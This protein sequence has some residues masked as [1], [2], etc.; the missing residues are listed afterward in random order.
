MLPIR[1]LLPFESNRT[2]RHPAWLDDDD[3]LAACDQK[4]LRRGGP[5]GQ[6]R[7]K[8]ET[9]VRLEHRET[10][11]VAEA[12]EHRTQRE[13]RHVA[14]RRLRLKLALAVRTPPLDYP[15]WA[16]VVA[17]RKVQAT[18]HARTGPQLVAHVLNVCDAVAFDLAAAARLLGVSKSQVVKF[19]R[20]DRTVMTAL[21]ERLREHG[22]PTVK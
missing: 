13:N 10:G 16:E 12:N 7:N 4:R 14:L 21:N 2:H 22:R 17:G 6:N 19:L 1:E 3:L 11:T 15:H 8:V 18:A 9:A 20:E 5:G